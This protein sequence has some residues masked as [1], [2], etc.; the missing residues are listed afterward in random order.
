VRVRIHLSVVLL[1]VLAVV[2]GGCG[3][4]EH[5]ATT[6]TQASTSVPTV[7]TAPAAVP[8]TS[9]ATTPPTTAAPKPTPEIQHGPVVET[10]R[11]L[12]I[13]KVPP[14]VL[15]ERAR[16][17]L[18]EANAVPVLKDVPPARRYEEKIYEPFLAVCKEAGK[19]SSANCECIVVKQELVKVEKGESLAELL[20][21]QV[22]FQKGETLAKVW[23]HQ[24]AVPTYAQRSADECKKV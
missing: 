24:A 20:A 13:S 19:G 23:R 12:G 10:L 5:A 7:T 1:A 4:S 14:K 22:A 6:V 17:L 15:K 3:S 16:K 21:L 18:A 2:A 11:K 8:T 9:S